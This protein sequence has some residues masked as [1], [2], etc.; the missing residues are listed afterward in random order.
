MIATDPQQPPVIAVPT[1][2][3]ADGAVST[4]PA[5]SVNAVIHDDYCAI[6]DE[7]GT[8]TCGATLAPTEARQNE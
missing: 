2:T 7:Y 6:H 1:G 4:E 5:T 3:G 8:C